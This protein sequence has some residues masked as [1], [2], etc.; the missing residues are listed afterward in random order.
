MVSNS[1]VCKDDLI[2]WRDSSFSAGTFSDF[3]MIHSNN[4]SNYEL[5]NE[6]ELEYISTCDAVFSLPDMVLYGFVVIVLLVIFL[7]IK[8]STRELP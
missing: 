5:F 6:S 8:E 4:D 2:A 7:F 3:K 1:G